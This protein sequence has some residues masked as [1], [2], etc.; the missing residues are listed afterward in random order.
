MKFV[1]S[2]RDGFVEYEG[3]QYI[4]VLE[5]EKVTSLKDLKK[6]NKKFKEIYPGKEILILEFYSGK[7]REIQM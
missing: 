7:W 4:K 2:V 5:K 3:N 1:I 6:L